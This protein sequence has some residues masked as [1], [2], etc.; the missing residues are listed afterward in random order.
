MWENHGKPYIFPFATIDVFFMF[1]PVCLWKK[2]SGALGIPL[3]SHR[4]SYSP[5]DSPFPSWAPFG[6]QFVI[7]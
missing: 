5:V 4:T 2:T 3:K 7:H 6:V 1:F